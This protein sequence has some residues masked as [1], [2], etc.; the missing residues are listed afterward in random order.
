MR[1]KNAQS[2]LKKNLKEYGRVLIV[3]VPHKSVLVVEQK[4][5]H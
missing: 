2:A 1:L 3:I 4:F 5:F